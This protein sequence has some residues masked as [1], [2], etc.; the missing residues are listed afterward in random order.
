MEKQ[1]SKPREEQ[2]QN[3]ESNSKSNIIRSKCIQKEDNTEYNLIYEK[4][5]HTHIFEYGCFIFILIFD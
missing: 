3:D 5:T 2:I 1:N 4:E